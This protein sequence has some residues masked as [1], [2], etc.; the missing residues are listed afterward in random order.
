MSG[1]LRGAWGM[2]GYCGKVLLHGQPQG[3][4]PTPWFFAG[5]VAV[6]MVLVAAGTVHSGMLLLG[7]LAPLLWIGRYPC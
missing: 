1:K 6:L 2:S 3:I 7:V 4:A 5:G